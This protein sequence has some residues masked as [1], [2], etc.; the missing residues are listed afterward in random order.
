MARQSFERD[1]NPMTS[2]PEVGRRILTRA[3]ALPLGGA[4]RDAPLTHRSNRKEKDP[5]AD[6]IEYP[7]RPGGPSQ[8]F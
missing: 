5:K 8:G 3:D 7:G 2:D 1:H 6:R 4:P